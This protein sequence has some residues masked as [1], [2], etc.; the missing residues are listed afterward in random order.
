LDVRLTWIKERRSTKPYTKGVT[1]EVQ[2]PEN[3]PQQVAGV[4]RAALATGDASAARVAA[5]FSMHPRTLNR[6]LGAYGTS[7]RDLLD[8]TRFDIA[9]HMLVGG[10]LDIKA[11]ATALDYAGARPFIRAF[12]RWSG[13]TPAQWRTSYGEG[14]SALVTLGHTQ[15]PAAIA[16]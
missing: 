12:R 6:R 1:P 16:P 5:L 13:T 14:K 7:F 11:I 3:F 9:Q 4:L 8:R 2:N 10:D 15:R